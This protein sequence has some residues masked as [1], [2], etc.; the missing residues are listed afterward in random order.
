MSKMESSVIFLPCRDLQATK[1]FYSRVLGLSIYQQTGGN[2]IFDTNYGYLGFVQ[3]YDGRPLATGV[4]ISF[5]CASRQQVDARYDE[6]KALP[7]CGVQAPPV[8]HAKFPVYSFFFTDPNGYTLEFQKL[9][10]E[11][12]AQ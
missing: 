10:E 11:G 6:L 7:E 3:Y 2:L 12:A 9:D 4:C 1:D 5:N 8:H